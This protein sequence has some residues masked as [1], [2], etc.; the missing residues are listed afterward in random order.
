MP[1]Q[2]FNTIPKDEISLKD[3]IDF[4]KR[5]W[6]TFTLC[7]LLGLGGSIIYLWLTPNLYQATA[8]INMAQISLDGKI[9]SESINIEDPNLL[10][11]RLKL[12]STYADQEIKSC[13]F[14]SSNDSSESFLGA[15]NLSVVKDAKSIVELKINHVNKEIAISCAQLIFERIRISQDELIRPYIEEAQNLRVKYEARLASAYSLVSQSDK[16]E[17][18]ISGLYLIAR[19]EIKFLTEEIWSLNTFISMAEKRQAKLI[20]PIYASDA[21]IFPKK[22]N[23]LIVGLMIG[24]FLGLFLALCKM[25]LANHKTS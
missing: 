13:G 1:E 4:L 8:K 25:I 23:S 2:S 22:K 14:G 12:P 7:G 9:Y 6:I 15:V 24:L 19:D 16:G 5:S 11:S 18:Y 20:A 3:A 10:I 17:A 21:P